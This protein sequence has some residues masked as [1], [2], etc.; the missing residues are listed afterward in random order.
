MTN[1]E[2]QQRWV[3]IVTEQRM[4]GMIIKKWCEN[5][6]ISHKSFYRWKSR[7]VKR[8]I[9]SKPGEPPK[10]TELKASEHHQF[11]LAKKTNNTNITKNTGSVSISIGNVE[12]NIN[13]NFSESTLSSV[14]RIVSSI[15]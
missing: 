14:L 6:N 4:S 10:S 5:H 1:N 15:C 13:D 11:I 12:I 7:L 9:I 3:E 8:G 2:L